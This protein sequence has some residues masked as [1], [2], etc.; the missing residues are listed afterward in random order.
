MLNASLDLIKVQVERLKKEN[1]ELRKEN[2]RL[3]EIV[4]KF[5]LKQ[6]DQ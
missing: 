1:E 2:A 4:T 3:Q 6:L 5:A